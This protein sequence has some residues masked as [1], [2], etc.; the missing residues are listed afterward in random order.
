MEE[1]L[2]EPFEKFVDSLYYSESE[3][4]GG[5]VMVS[6]LEVPPLTSDALL[7]TLHPFLENVNGVIRRVHELSVRPS[8]KVV[9]L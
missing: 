9:F 7:T 6:V 5:A 8:Y 1:Q 4:C 3:L 2:R